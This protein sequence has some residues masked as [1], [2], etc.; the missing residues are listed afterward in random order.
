MKLSIRF[1]K[2]H[3]HWLCR[4]RCAKI[5]SPCHEQLKLVPEDLSDLINVEN[6]DQF[7]LQHIFTFVHSRMIPLKKKTLI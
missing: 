3:F 4:C 6:L 5:H 2:V 1:I 7:N